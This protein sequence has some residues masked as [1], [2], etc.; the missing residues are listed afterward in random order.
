[1]AK[2]RVATGSCGSHRYV[3]RRTGATDSKTSV[4]SSSA[5]CR[6]P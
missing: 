1:M 3:L 4:A 6:Y 5:I 2:M